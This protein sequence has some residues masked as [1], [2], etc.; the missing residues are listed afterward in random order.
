MLQRYSSRRQK[1]SESLLNQRLAG[2]KQY[3][4]IAGYFA[5]S[6]FDVSGEA[7]EQIEGKVRIVCNAHL[8]IDDVRSVKAYESSIRQEWCEESP[9]KAHVGYPDRLTKL[10]ALLK[11]GKLEVRVVPDE[12]FGFIHGK[13]GVVTLG[14]GSKTSFLGS[15][16][17][18]QSGWERNYELVW[19]DDSEG[20]VDWVQEEFDTLWNHESARPLIDFIVEDIQRIAERK[21]IYEIEKVKKPEESIVES[22]VY[23]GGLGLWE[24][25]KYFID[26]VFRTKQAGLNARYILADMVGLGKTVQLGLSAQI[27]SLDSNKPVLIIAPKT[28]LYQ[29]QDELRDLM[30][31]PSAVWDGKSWI[32][33][34][35]NTTTGRRPDDIRRCPRKIGIVSQGIITARTEAAE[36]LLNVEY[37]TVIVDECH[38][39]RRKNLHKD[40]QAQPPEPNNLYSYLMRI[41][42]KTEHMLMGTATPV[43]LL[44]V[45]AWDLLNILAQGDDRVMG[46]QASPW[47]T[48]VDDALDILSGGYEIHSKQELWD[49]L[50]N[51]FPDG[52]RNPM[53]YRVLREQFNMKPRDYFAVSQY[54]ELSPHERSLFEQ[55]SE[56]FAAKYNPFITRIIRR[57]RKYLETTVDPATGEPYLLPIHVKLFGEDE[58]EALPLTVYLQDA[59]AKAEQIAADM[60][61]NNSGFITTMILRRVGSSM[62]AGKIT[63]EK[64]LQKGAGEQGS[65]LEI[66][67][68]EEDE[69]SNDEDTLKAV[70]GEEIE[71]DAPTK[72]ALH[73]FLSII[74]DKLDSDPKY[75]LLVKLL[76]DEKWVDMGCIIFSQ[77]FDTVWW[78]AEKLVRDNVFPDQQIAIYAGGDKSGLFV[79]GEFVKRPKDELKRMVKRGEIKIIFGTDAASEGLNL[80]TLGTLINIDLPWN[81]TKLEQRKGR[82]QRIGQKRDEVYV[83]NMRYKDSVED[84]VHRALSD[85]LKS[86]NEIFGQ[87]PDVLESAWTLVAQGKID[88]AKK[89]INEL[90][91]KSPFEAK[92]ENPTMVQAYDW[93]RCSKVLDEFI[94]VEHFKARW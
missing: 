80:Q 13:A 43:Q 2:A 34:E 70:K 85:R 60:G 92:Y 23:R 51:P 68:T 74:S 58:K 63:A 69:G 56:D 77:Y 82:I 66:S 6:L 14:D 4:R 53:T 65:E 1:L 93:E 61:H 9:E 49:W 40:K 62:Y 15:M 52:M 36:S 17:E 72:S 47:R 50:R 48:R 28:L 42:K 18:S 88:E 30:G 75:G 20:S 21:V 26:L 79:N 16:N 90:P 94:K 86:I 22:P 81:P 87:V 35:G 76:R 19:E 41:S 37:N 91:E 78:F 27:L 89:T 33:E 3:D 55:I 45:E 31:L 84:K 11:S 24:H 59:Y 57:T 44:P 71:I 39:S 12:I 54:S 83:Y 5:T 8:Q 67:L 46:S 29:W 73:E 10:Y 7:L 38:R 25:Q 64:M 32:D